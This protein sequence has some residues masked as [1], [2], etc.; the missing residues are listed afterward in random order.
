MSN[1]AHVC[2]I[3]CSNST[4]L[5]MT[6]KYKKVFFFNTAITVTRLPCS[7]DLALSSPPDP[8]MKIGYSCPV[9]TGVHFDLGIWHPNLSKYSNHVHTV[10]LT[11]M[12]KELAIVIFLL[13]FWSSF[14]RSAK[15]HLPSFLLWI[16]FSFNLSFWPYRQRCPLQKI[17]YH[18][19]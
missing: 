1:S 4:C 13:W 12:Q 5:C 9:I 19:N 17:M 11:T 16:T 2:Y 18:W 6:K 3:P 14:F 7:F 15:S 8:F 10:F